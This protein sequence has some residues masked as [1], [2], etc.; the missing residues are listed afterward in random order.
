L[1]PRGKNSKDYLKMFDVPKFSSK[2]DPSLWIYQF[3]KAATM[4]KWDERTKL[5]YVDNCFNEKLQMWFMQQ[6]FATWDDFKTPFLNKF[7]KKVNFDKIA[8]NLINFKMKS[9]E[10]I[11]EYIERYEELRSKYLLESAKRKRINANMTKGTNDNKPELSI[12]D[13]SPPI[14][15]NVTISENGFLNYFIEGVGS[16]SIKRFLRTEKPETLQEAY[17]LLKE[18]YGPE[19]G[20]NPE[21]FEDDS[22]T[23]SLESYESDTETKAKTPKKDISTKNIK[24][25]DKEPGVAELINELKNMTLLIGE[26]VS[27]K[28]HKG[29]TSAKNNKPSCWNCLASDHLTKDCVK[30]CKLCNKQGHKHYE[31]T[32]Y[33]KNKP[34]HNNQAQSESMLIEE[35]YLS[36]KRNIGDTDIPDTE[37]SRNF[38]VSRSGKTVSTPHLK[39]SVVNHSNPTSMLLP[40][41]ESEP[42]LKSKIDR[43]KSIQL[44][45]THPLNPDS[46]STG[47]AGFLQIKREQIIDRLFK[48]SMHELSLDEI[49][50]LSPSARTGFK[51]RFTKP[52]SNKKA[53]VEVTDHINT[54]AMLGE[55]IT[56]VPKGRSAPRTHGWVNGEPCEVILDGGCTSYIISL[57][58]AKSIGIRELEPFNATVLFGDGVHREPVGLVKNLR[59]QVGDSP[60]ISIDALCFDV[61]KYKFIVGREGLHAL[62]I[63]ADWSTHFWYIKRD[64]GTIPL[65]TYYTAVINRESVDTEDEVENDEHDS[66]EDD[67]I[68]QDDVEEGY[69]IME[70]SDKE[71]ERE[72]ASNN[73][74]RFGHLID[75]I[76]DQ[77]NLNKDEKESLI[78]LLYSYEDCFGTQYEHLSQ[79]NLLKFHVDTGNAKPIYRR[80]YSF[81]SFSEKQD[82]KKDLEE[83]SFPSRY[84]PKKTG[85]KRLISNFR[86]LNASLA[87]SK[88]F[89]LVDLLKAFQQIAVE[90]ESIP[91][92][93]IATPW[94]SYSYRCVPFGVLNGPAVFSRCVYLSI[95]PFLGD[96]A[97]NYLDDVTIYSKYKSDHLNHIEKFLHRMREVNLKINANKCDFYQ[98][99]ITLLGFVISEKGIAPSPSKVSKIMEFPRPVNETGVRGF[100][101][102]CGF[103]RR[104]IPGFAD[105]SVPL[106]ELLKKKNPFNWNDACENAFKAMKKA[107]ISAT[108]LMIP[109]ANTEY[110][111]YCDASEV[112]IGAC[113][114]A[115]TDE[116]EKPVLYLSRKLQPAE[117]RY[118]TVEKEL[119]AVIYALKKLRKYLLDRKFTLFRDNTAVCYLFNKNEPSQRLQRW[120]MCTQ[121]FVFDVVH[122]PSTKN[123]VAYALSRFPPKLNDD[124][125]DGEDFIEALYDHLMIEEGPNQ[126]EA[127]LGD[128]I[129]YF[130]NC[131]YEARSLKTKR[132]SLKYL[133]ENG[134]LYRKIGLRHVL[135]PKFYERRRILTEIH[136][137]HGH[138][139]V[140]A[141][142]ARLYQS[143]WWPSCYADIREHVKTCHPCQLFSSTEPNPAVQRVPVNY[144]FEQFSLD[145]VGPLP[146]S[147]KGNLHILV[148]AKTVA[149]FLYRHIFC[150]YGPPTHIPSDNGSAFDNEI[151]NNFTSLVNVHHQFTSPY[152]PS[153][154]GR[155]E[156]MNGTIVKAL[157]KLSIS[158]PL[159]WDEHIDAVLYAYRTEAHSVLKVSP[160]EY[161]YGIAPNSSRMNPLQ[162]LGRALGMERLVA[163]NDRNVQI[164][165]Y[166]VLKDEYDAKPIVRRKYFESG[167]MVVR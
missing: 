30:P 38:R 87:N 41:L 73:S 91:K 126:Y 69:L 100:V 98:Q 62:K 86:E 164:D 67:Y 51:S 68:D 75:R 131:G 106:N 146:K 42:Y 144:I 133:Y 148:E 18:V 137:G 111:L 150:N 29:N 78:D 57:S 113:L 95:Q 165:Y 83:M 108:T 71:E 63:G 89:S 13:E 138:F 50:L 121:E 12:S 46:K 110:N 35:V 60:V 162:L 11:L 118:P 125:E 124:D 81:S 65:N 145:F 70:A 82:L 132:L 39:R 149:N 9:N 104:H 40:S 103:Y 56:N 10:N 96:F 147:T 97:T 59:L 22:D 24:T 2:D 33:K 27:K 101:N 37:N 107:L 15:E 167:T 166:N 143:Y 99:E 109:D 44:K 158:N 112:G 26:L 74:E 64:D 23:E 14:Q 80:P 36:E 79:T 85:D 47:D 155:T 122:L 157:K 141:S 160:Y 32:L 6:N 72:H 84:V 45:P 88:W 34:G 1:Y 152:R 49:S 135:V 31:C 119:L 116:G 66:Y 159:D 53:H 140:N 105:L 55:T 128:L 52:Q 20:E 115:I 163:L 117:T 93:T 17:H 77:D 102:L 19:V 61:D 16:N 21:K 92:L 130:R 142:W 25:V 4:N 153:T 129:N 3:S 7:T 156:Q 134:T 90:E 151:V 136:D 94:G 28:N 48:N 8:S 58:F 114:A 154:N 123:S 139:G 43:S 120:V 76:K 127:W 54:S 5:Y 161:M